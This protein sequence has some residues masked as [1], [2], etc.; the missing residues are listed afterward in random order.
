MYLTITAIRFTSIAFLTKQLNIR[1]V[2]LT[3]TGER[4]N[5]IIFQVNGTAETLAF[6]T[7]SSVYDFLGGLRNVPTLAKT[8]K[9]DEQ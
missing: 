3:T 4:N 8:E 6:T 7:I 9:A 2:T 1:S 5:V